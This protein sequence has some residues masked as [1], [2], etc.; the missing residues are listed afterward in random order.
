MYEERPRD[1][2]VSGPALHQGL[3]QLDVPKFLA[4]KAVRAQPNE[5]IVGLQP[6][7]NIATMI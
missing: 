2:V 3:V 6:K 5:V 1:K 7:P 4:L